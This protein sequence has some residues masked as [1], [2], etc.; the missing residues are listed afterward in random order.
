MKHFLLFAIVFAVFH[1][2]NS[3]I[4]D[5]CHLT[6]DEGVGRSF[7]ISLYYD[8]NNDQCSPFIYK[9]QGGNSNRFLNE[10]ECMKNCSTN[11]ARI[12]PTDAMASCHLTKLN[13]GCNG[14]FLRYYYDSVHG[15]C[16]KF[17][18][19]G[20]HGNGNRFF[21]HDS[22]NATCAGIYDNRAE[23]EEDEP[24]TPIAIICGVLLAVIV[25]SIIITIIVLT[26]Q[27]NKKQ[28][29]SAQ[30]KDEESEAPIKEQSLEMA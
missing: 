12:Y 24:D 4:P 3:D 9:G 14:R 16:K 29:A 2:G 11:I 21:D 1:L 8:A 28:K 7:I 23:E 25:A 15:K 18:W 26:V 22:C 30:S 6:E 13:G 5:F 19:T 27:S 17:L 20:C 10:R